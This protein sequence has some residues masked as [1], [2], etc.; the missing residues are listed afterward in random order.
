KLDV[1]GSVRV[2]TA[3]YLRFADGAAFF[4]DLG[5]QSSLSV[6][7]V[8]AFGFLRAPTAGITVNG[9]SLQ[10]DP[11]KTLSLVGGDIQISGGA[12]VGNAGSLVASSGRIELASV[13]SAGEGTLVNAAGAPDL[14]VT[15]FSRL[16]SITIS[17]GA[18][19]DVSGAPGPSGSVVIRGG[20][21]VVNQATILAMTTDAVSG[22][23]LAVDVQIRGDAVLTNSGIVSLTMGSGDAGDIHVTAGNLQIDGAA[24]SSN[25]IG[26]GRGADVVV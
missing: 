24:I 3:D 15:S 14:G 4:T 17:D 9:S 19:L 16:G 25:T 1:G 2:S 7:D 21:L 20:Q 13:A 8:T 5:R 22:A 10:V 12:S 6:A 26:S 23:G 18:L 11:G